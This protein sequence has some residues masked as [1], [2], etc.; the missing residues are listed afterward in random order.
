MEKE[1]IILIMVI[2]MKEIGRLREIKEW[3]YLSSFRRNAELPARCETG[4][5][6]RW[7]PGRGRQE[8][9]FRIRRG[10]AY[11]RAYPRHKDLSP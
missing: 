8:A 10:T 3:E 2:D 11:S 9:S 6:C 4:S 7:L 1:Y 5:R